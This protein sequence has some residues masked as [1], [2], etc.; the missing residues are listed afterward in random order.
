MGIPHYFYV[1]TKTY[2]GLCAD[3]EDC[4]HFFVDFNGM[5][6]TAANNV[7]KEFEDTELPDEAIEGVIIE[8]TWK[9]LRHCVDMISPTTCVHVCTDGVA[10]L[11]KINQQRKRRYLSVFGQTEAQSA[12]WNRNAI[13]PHT[14]FMDRLGEA[15]R[16]KATADNMYFSGADEPG[17][18]EHKI[19]ERIASLPTDANVY[20]YGL[21]ADLIMLSLSAHR[22]GIVLMRESTAKSNATSSTD[23]FTF[24]NIDALREGIQSQLR[25]KYAWPVETLT[26]RDLIDTYVTLCFLLGNDF[27]PHNI[28]L[29]LKKNGHD[30]LLTAAKEAFALHPSG[31][32]HDQTI[33]EHFLLAVMQELQKDETTIVLDMVNEYQN[34][35]PRDTRIG[36]RLKYMQFGDVAISLT[37]TGE[38]CS[39]D[40]LGQMVLQSPNQWRSM[41]YKQLFMTRDTKAVVDS[42]QAFITGIY[43]TYAYYNRLPKD[44]MYQYPYGYAPTILDLSNHLTG[45]L[46]D[47]QHVFVRW[48]KAPPKA[49]S[50]ITQLMCIMPFPQSINLLPEQYH[51]L[52]MDP[53]HG[54]RHM[55]PTAYRVQ[56]FLKSYLWECTPVLPIIDVELLENYVTGFK[57][58]A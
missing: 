9:Y 49:I 3:I 22:K 1:I 21:D 14:P 19:F 25:D 56:T 20:V 36:N 30:R 4:D 44:P 48:S 10:P 52:I 53:K 23:Q 40:P 7:L 42:C 38:I 2:N 29:N 11:A 13:S 47:W 6:H 17:E 33:N 58:K 41:Y 27:L 46:D 32:V 51:E 57:G 8:E 55:F 50:P 5:I 43:W 12:R 31:L 26:S 39:K 34:H 18:G 45:T 15:I 28:S 37:E 16:A 54:C 24:L 35:R